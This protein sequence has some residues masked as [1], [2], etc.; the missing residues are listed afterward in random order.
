MGRTSILIAVA[1]VITFVVLLGSCGGGPPVFIPGLPSAPDPGVL[2]PLVPD[3]LAA[4]GP[5]TA[6]LTLEIDAPVLAVGPSA[7]LPTPIQFAVPKMDAPLGLYP[8]SQD[9]P[10]RQQSFSP[11]EW[12][13]GNP[14]TG[15][16]RY[17]ADFSSVPLGNYTARMAW[18]TYDYTEDYFEVLR[19]NPFPLTTAAPSAT[20]TLTY[21][22]LRGIGVLPGSILY[23]PTDL[24]DLVL[25][26]T[27]D[28]PGTTGLQVI[29]YTLPQGSIV[30]GRLLFELRGTPLAHYLVSATHSA[31]FSAGYSVTNN[32]ASPSPRAAL[33][34][35]NKPLFRHWPI[36]AGDNMFFGYLVLTGAQDWEGDL[37]IVAR[38]AGSSPDSA[39]TTWLW[40]DRA[41]SIS[42]SD[43]YASDPWHAAF[44]MNGLP[45]GMPYGLAQL[46]LGSYDIYAELFGLLPGQKLSIKLA[47]DEP[48]PPTNGSRLYRDPEWTGAPYWVMTPLELDLTEEQAQA[49]VLEP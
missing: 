22:D 27:F 13:S 34:G 46:P 19:T 33:Y 3:P 20:Q 9:R 16:Y 32:A 38:P 10:V 48:L 18:W 14:A 11:G 49:F 24:A 37:R 39:P 28:P 21:S 36:R 12:S 41:R 31:D 6:H 1:V 43:M 40:F 45:E 26:F 8:D 7:L 2:P 35:Y 17:R 30:D 47:S 15:V 44:W 5:A 4:A 29:D 25:S 23:S 42:Y